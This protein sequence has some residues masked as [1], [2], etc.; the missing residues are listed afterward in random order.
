MKTVSGIS[1]SSV[2]VVAFRKGKGY[3]GAQVKS[4]KSIIDALRDIADDTLA[5]LGGGGGKAY[6]PDSEQDGAPYLTVGHAE[7]DDLSLVEALRGGADLP[8]VSIQD[9]SDRTVVAYSLVVGGPRATRWLF[10]KRFSPV[11]VAGKKILSQF[12]GAL[13]EIT[14]AIFTF[15]DSFDVVISPADAWTTRQTH[16]EG[17]FKESDVVLAE[18]GTWVKDFAKHVPLSAASHKVLEDRLRT[19]QMLRRKMR[20]I[21]RRG[22]LAK[23]TIVDI[24]AALSRYDFDPHTCIVSGELVMTDENVV[25]L[26]QMLNEDLFEGNFSAQ[27]FAAGRKVSR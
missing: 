10:V 15:D 1:N 2:L 19:N 20:S 16:F 23:V 17:L 18:V 4:D 26:V 13:H 24:T 25:P 21:Q 5:V 12:D 6:D 9:I 27:A 3:E 8:T 22:H 7:V 11:T 14:G